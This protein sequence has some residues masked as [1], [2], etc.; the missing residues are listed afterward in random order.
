MKR[1]ELITKDTSTLRIF[2]ML[3][4]S[5]IEDAGEFSYFVSGL[6]RSYGAPL[7]LSK[8]RTSATFAVTMADA[9]GVY[10]L[11]RQQER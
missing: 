5:V 2:C 7:D 10:I 3:D 4:V 11:N 1:E 6:E 9:L 8:T